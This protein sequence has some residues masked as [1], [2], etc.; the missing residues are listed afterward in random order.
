D[1]NF[2]NEFIEI[3]NLFK[4]VRN[5]ICHN[6]PIYDFNYHCYNIYNFLK[7]NSIEIKCQ[8]DNVYANIY[9]VIQCLVLFDKFTKFPTKKDLAKLIR[10]CFDK[11]VKTN[12]NEN[13]FE[14]IKK[15]FGFS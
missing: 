12:L 8:P 9:I 10:E 1:N 3:M 11:I 2:I 6:E 4:I 15:R 7:A 14:Y 5:K 13:S